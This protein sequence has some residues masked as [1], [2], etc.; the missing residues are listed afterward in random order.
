MPVHRANPSRVLRLP[1]RGTLLVSGDIHGNL[2]DFQRV[3]QLYRDALAGDPETYLLFLGDL[4]HG[5]PAAVTKDW[6]MILGERYRDQSARVVAAFLKLERAYPRRVFSLLGNHD[7]SHVGGP[8]TGKFHADETRYLES[9]MTAREIAAMRGLFAR[10][11]LLA[12]AANGLA[13]SHASPSANLESLADVETLSYRGFLH[14]TS[15]EML[16]DAGF[17][18]RILWNRCASEQDVENYLRK[19]HGRNG[20][21][22]GVAIYSH[23]VVPDGIARIGAHQICLCTSFG[24]DRPYKT[25]LKLDLAKDYRRVDD[26]QDQVEV[27]R[28]YDD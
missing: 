17:L 10:L 1:E 9:T 13:F 5:P 26:L 20:T 15:R 8:H 19:V 12:V 24:L 25:Y 27:L 2:L 14:Y 21:A 18:G 11:P 4:V 16:S 23:D 3:V 7:H 6:R 22:E 28:L